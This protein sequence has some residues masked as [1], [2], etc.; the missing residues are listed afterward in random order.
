MIGSRDSPDRTGGNPLRRARY[1]HKDSF[2][3]LKYPN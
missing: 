2:D 1:L 3:L